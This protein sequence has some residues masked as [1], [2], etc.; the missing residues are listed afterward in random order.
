MNGVHQNGLVNSIWIPGTRPM[1]IAN[2]AYIPNGDATRLG[3]MD[4]LKV[5]DHY[6]INPVATENYQ[7][8]LPNGHAKVICGLQ[9]PKVQ[10]QYQV[11]A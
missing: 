3:G 11:N 5:P 8:Y 4:S 1:G 2:P 6:Q 7:A 10:G 9:P